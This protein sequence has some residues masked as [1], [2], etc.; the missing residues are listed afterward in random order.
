MRKMYIAVVGV[1]LLGA[2]NLVHAQ[3][4]TPGWTVAKVLD[5]RTMESFCY[6]PPT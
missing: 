3:D 6:V 4:V 5:V 1:F 2:V